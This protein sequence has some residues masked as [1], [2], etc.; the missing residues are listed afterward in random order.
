MLA[1]LIT[2]VTGDDHRDAVRMRIVEPLGL[3]KMRLGVP[4]DDIRSEE[5]FGY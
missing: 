4:D 3:S 1:E 5:F 2:E